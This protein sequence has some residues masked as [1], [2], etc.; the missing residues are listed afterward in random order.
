MQRIICYIIIHCNDMLN[1]DHDSKVQNN[2]DLLL[3]TNVIIYV[4]LFTFR[5]QNL[6]FSN[7]FQFLINMKS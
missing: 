2:T 3:V 6:L 5:K 1:E 7:K 4:L